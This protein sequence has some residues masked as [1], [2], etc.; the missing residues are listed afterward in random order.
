MSNQPEKFTMSPERM[1]DTAKSFNE[2]AETIST[3]LE[4]LNKSVT[5]LLSEWDG[6]GAH[7]FEGDFTSLKA[8]CEK[9]MGCVTERA[10]ALISS[11]NAAD[12]LAGK[13]RDQWA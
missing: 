5:D 10:E 13:I 2:N 9:M 3:S 11:A 8:A 1:R 7:E 4:N 6:A 12:E